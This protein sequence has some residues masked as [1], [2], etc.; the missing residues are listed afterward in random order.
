MANRPRGAFFKQS[1]N[2]ERRGQSIAE[3]LGSAY[4]TSHPRKTGALKPVVCVSRNYFFD[5]HTK[6]TYPLSSYL[7]DELRTALASTGL[8]DLTTDA[9]F[10]SDYVLTGKYHRGKT[11]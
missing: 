10:D 9:D 3:K 6:A 7:A 4:R 5:P 11:T 1:R 8:F 2:P